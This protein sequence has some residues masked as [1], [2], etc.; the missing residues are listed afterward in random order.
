ML[1]QPLATNLQHHR[2][3]PTPN[4]SYKCFQP[5]DPANLSILPNFSNLSP[6]TS[7]LRRLLL[8]L[9]CDAASL[10]NP[11][12]TPTSAPLL[13]CTWNVRGLSTRLIEVQS[14]LMQAA[15]YVVGGPAQTPDFLILTETL[16]D[17]QLSRKASIRSRLEGAPE[18]HT[19]AA[20][21][22]NLSGQALKRK[23][24]KGVCIIVK[25]CWAPYTTQATVSDQLRGSVCIV[26]VTHGAGGPLATRIIGVYSPCND[27][28]LRGAVHA[29]ILVEQA[30]CANAPTPYHLIIAGDFNAALFP[31]DRPE[32]L[33]R[34]ADTV[35]ASLVAAASLQPLD[36]PPPNGMRAHSWDNAWGSSSRIDDILC[37]P[38]TLAAAVSLTRHVVADT[39]SS[40]HHM[41]VAAFD[42]AKLGMTRPLPAPT[43]P[44]VTAPPRIP[45]SL[46]VGH[47]E[48]I[49]LQVLRECQTLI[50]DLHNQVS[51]YI[52]TSLPASQI[53]RANI[54][55][56]IDNK[57]KQLHDQ[58]F[59][60][61]DQ[62]CNGPG[63]RQ[64]RGDL[65]PRAQ[66]TGFLPEGVSMPMCAERAL[67]AL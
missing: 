9:S 25:A 47:L 58:I 3:D 43:A 14:L 7:A 65:P 15:T 61:A 4:I 6:I 50:L 59:R 42:T 39:G 1:S 13:L 31:S 26:N 53:S 30:A 67:V 21:F 27:A 35:W 11:G 51:S 18:A 66:P 12:P 64:T 17:G 8:L 32:L 19:Y 20:Y 48:K 38:H 54:I 29:L 16:T 23:H 34:R 36:P 63:L 46:P 10:L 33:R 44:P 2:R 41:V 57:F 40:D 45:S 62:V 5:S 24:R 52:T 49:R 22:S 55:Q 37:L 28:E 60:V 56:E